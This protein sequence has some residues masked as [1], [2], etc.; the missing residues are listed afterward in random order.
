LGINF[1]TGKVIQIYISLIKAN[2]HH[3]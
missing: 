1:G 3:Q 2:S